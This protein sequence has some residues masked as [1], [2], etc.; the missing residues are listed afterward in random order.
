LVL[1]KERIFIFMREPQRV[2]SAQALLQV[3]RFFQDV[4]DIARI[5]ATG[6]GDFAVGKG[7]SLMGFGEFNQVLIGGRKHKIPMVNQKP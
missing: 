7:A 2:D 3:A 1:S 4:M 5:Q 6:P